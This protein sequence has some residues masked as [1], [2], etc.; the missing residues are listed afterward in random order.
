MESNTIAAGIKNLCLG[1]DL[2]EAVASKLGAVPKTTVKP[3]VTAVQN[4]VKNGGVVPKT[5]GTTA[6]V[7]PV[8]PRQTGPT[9]AM[10]KR[11]KRKNRKDRRKRGDEEPGEGA[12][13]VRRSASDAA[14]IDTNG[15]S[16][17]NI[18][19]N[20]EIHKEIFKSHSSVNVATGVRNLP[21]S[22]FSD[23]LPEEREEREQREKSEA[24]LSK[25]KRKRLGKRGKQASAEDEDKKSSDKENE[26]VNKVEEAE[27]VDDEDPEPVQGLDGDEGTVV[28]KYFIINIAID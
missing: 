15:L 1:D 12:D 8:G 3:P 17:K 26:T 22:F 25:G 19:G 10:A 6:A 4:N 11:Q 21:D 14:L 23:E 18:A 24:K 2:A 7:P 9:T 5:N 20:E 16:S 27:S 28:T 13:G